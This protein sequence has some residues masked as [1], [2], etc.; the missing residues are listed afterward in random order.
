MV[1]NEWPQRVELGS[2]SAARRS[3]G[4]AN[5]ENGFAQMGGLGA[6]DAGGNL[7]PFRVPTSK[8]QVYMVPANTLTASHNALQH[9]QQHVLQTGEFR[10]SV[11][12]SNHFKFYHPP[13]IQIF[14]HFHLKF[15]LQIW[16]YLAF[17]VFS[18]HSYSKKLF[19]LS[20]FVYFSTS[21][22]YTAKT[23]QST[24]L[25]TKT[26]KIQYN[27]YII[28]VQ[29]SQ[30]QIS[31]C[32]NFKNSIIRFLC[33]L[34]FLP[35]IKALLSVCYSEQHHLLHI[36]WFHLTIFNSDTNAFAHVYFNY[37]TL[38][39]PATIALCI[40]SRCNSYL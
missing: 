25:L 39:Q 17:F 20:T 12:F 15:Q 13:K 37:Y 8:G 31:H 1:P 9:T 32:C 36:V 38:K 30:K 21:T 27:N 5:Y 19:D 35:S 10:V 11:S 16:A 3:S 2:S 22:Y 14:R 34:V 23:I 4:T 29:I 6:R 28:K 24:Q 33:K 18:I 7:G 26:H 40:N